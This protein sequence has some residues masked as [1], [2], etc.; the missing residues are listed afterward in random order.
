MNRRMLLKGAGVAGALVGAGAFGKY[1]VLAPPRSAELESVDALAVRICDSLSGD[2]KA[3][4]CLPYDHPLRQYHN[5][6]L[7]AGGLVVSALTVDWG[8]R[9]ALTDLLHAGLSEAG[10]ER[11]PRQDST[12][13]FGANGLGLAVCGDPRRGPYQIMLSG[14]HLNLRLG[15]ASADG[16]AFGG[17]QVYGDQRGNERVG[18]PGNVYRYQMEAAHRLLAALTPAERAA[19]RVARAPAQV[20][21][22]V[23]GRDGRFDGVVVADLA[24]DKRKLAHDV[25]AGIVDTYAERDTAYAW[26]CLERNG[27]VDAL[28]FA[29]YDEDYEGGRRAGDAPSQ[30]FRFE[31]PAAV[32]HFRGEPHVHAFV[33]IAMDGERP[34]S[35]GDALAD[36]PA[37]L[38]GE[39]LAAFFETA[40]RAQGEA[41]VAL[42][43][44]QGAVGRLR[45]GTV[46]TGDIWTAE[47]W[48]NDLVVVEAKG[49][50]LAPE[51]ADLMRSRGTPPQSGSTYRIATTDYIADYE[52]GAHLGRVGA[53]RSLGPL[54]DALVAHAREHGFARG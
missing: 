11:L 40:M 50:D 35:V 34:L 42:Y 21:V 32:F 8:T 44:A 53:R 12:N 46:R 5:R 6:G 3:L 54:R 52:A 27:G 28:R 33:N 37:V 31:G 24:A 22:G 38:E 26:Q 41:D 17:P 51:M 23:Q 9:R 48:V 36:N 16:A 14:V 18:L 47:S 43:P 7:W 25:V 20:R 30:I 2:A 13:W 39:D 19:V 10:R 1:A 45:A 29:D 4:A 49:A 15:G